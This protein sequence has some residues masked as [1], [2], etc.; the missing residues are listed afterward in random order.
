MASG[1]SIPDG[2]SNISAPAFKI[3]DCH[4]QQRKSVQNRQNRSYIPVEDGQKLIQNWRWIVS[5][6]LNL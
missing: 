5:K 3:K 4:L 2:T 6:A 1:N